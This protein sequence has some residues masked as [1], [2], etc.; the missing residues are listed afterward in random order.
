MLDR[1]AR[2]LEGEESAG[3]IKLKS[4]YKGRESELSEKRR[5]AEENLKKCNFCEWKCGVNR[6]EELGVCS[7]NIKP[8][9]ASFF[10]HYGE[11]SVLV[12]SFTIFFSGCN[13]HCVFCQ[14]WDIS[15]NI[16][17]EYIPPE[18]MARIIEKRKGIRNVNWVGGEPT[19]NIHYV[20][21]VLEHMERNIPQVWNSNMYMSEDAMEILSGV[22][23]IY[24]SDF[25]YGNDKCGLKSSRVKNYFEVVSR[26]HKIAYEQ[27]DL[28]IRHLIMPGH[29][30]CCTK[31]I[32]KWIAD[33]VPNAAVNL[34][35][36]YHPDYLAY[37]YPEINRRIRRSEYM[38]AYQY[39]KE[40]GLNLVDEERW[41][42]M[43]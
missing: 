10:T 17:G 26:N 14:N 7:V 24:L 28:L 29:L 36:Q 18:K 20:L 42:M 13:F 25:K 37:R 15:Q 4:Y 23:D 35:A 33:N 32:L 34:M 12:P 38:A 6:Y 16:V 22:V 27:A 2:I 8:K 5:R 43:I 9:I 31:K 11:E 21:S 39:A 19:P 30:E 1:Y 41:L 40:L 3:F